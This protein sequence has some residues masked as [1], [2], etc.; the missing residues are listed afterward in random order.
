MKQQKQQLQKQLHLC[1][2]LNSRHR[3]EP[4]YALIHT[5]NFLGMSG[6]LVPSIAHV[7]E[8][9]NILIFFPCLEFL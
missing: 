8:I 3:I 7:L 6:K 1:C 2:V 5:I 4:F 9:R